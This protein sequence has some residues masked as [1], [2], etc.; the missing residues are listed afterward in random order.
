M[1]VVIEPVEKLFCINFKIRQNARF[2]WF[3]K[4]NLWNSV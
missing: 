4:F 1:E 2:L 3:K